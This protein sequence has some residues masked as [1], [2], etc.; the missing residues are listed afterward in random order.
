MPK[1]PQML[2]NGCVQ[3][4]RQRFKMAV[5]R[6]TLTSTGEV[7]ICSSC[8]CVTKYTCLKCEM[9]LCNKCSIFEANEDTTG[10]AN[11]VQKTGNLSVTLYMRRNE[12]QM[13]PTAPIK[14]NRIF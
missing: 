8:F 11:R 14:K 4:R 9:S 5:W 6:T 13:V 10:F 12:D 3:A 1:H 7:H 2:R